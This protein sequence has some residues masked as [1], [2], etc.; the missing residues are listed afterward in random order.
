MIDK[1]KKWGNSQ[2]LRFPQYIMKQ[3]GI[4]VGDTVEISVENGRI[5]IVPKRVIRG[6]H[7]LEDL[8]AAMPENYC[9]QGEEW[10]D[11]SGNESW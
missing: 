7:K 6:K 10:G 9:A 4:K 8:V 5:V 3:A 11:P 1:I 2:G